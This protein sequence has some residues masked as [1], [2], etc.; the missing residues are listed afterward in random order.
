MVDLSVIFAIVY[1][2]TK[3]A[4]EKPHPTKGTLHRLQKK[5]LLRVE[6]SAL[7]GQPDMF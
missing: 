4:E 1:G 6:S 7:S 3:Q 5:S 2:P